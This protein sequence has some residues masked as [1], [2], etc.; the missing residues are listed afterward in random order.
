MERVY[1]DLDG[2]EK[3]IELSRMRG[4]GTF[5]DDIEECRRHIE[6]IIELCTDI[7]NSSN[8]DSRQVFARIAE[9]L[10]DDLSFIR[11]NENRINNNNAQAIQ[12]LNSITQ[13][14]KSLA[15]QLRQ[16]IDVVKKMDFENKDLQNKIQSLDVSQANH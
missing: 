15:S 10:E 16:V 8:Q 7:K 2:I 5:T 9:K 11:K 6:L 3:D 14:K 12:K 13:N 1:Q 4:L